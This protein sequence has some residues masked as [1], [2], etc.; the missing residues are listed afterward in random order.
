MRFFRH[1]EG[2][3]TSALLF[4]RRR[5]S[6]Y[7]PSQ[8]P[9]TRPEPMTGGQGNLKPI[10]LRVILKGRRSSGLRLVHLVSAAQFG[11][12]SVTNERTASQRTKADGANFHIWEPL[13]HGHRRKLECRTDF[14]HQLA[15]ILGCGRILQNSTPRN[16]HRARGDSYVG[17]GKPP[18]IPP[19]VQGPSQTWSLTSLSTGFAF[20]QSSP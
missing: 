7:R 1:R 12:P 18:D 14:L 20:S 15:S 9:S 8:N 16:A 2:F 10:G 19:Q 5:R 4:P 17:I 3:S 6:T 11:G 13:Q